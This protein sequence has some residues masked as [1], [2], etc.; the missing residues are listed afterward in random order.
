MEVAA[1]VE[2]VGARGLRAI[3]A[4]AG[5]QVR[6]ASDDRFQSGG[7]GLLIELDRTEH[8]AVIGHRDRLHPGGFRMFDQRADLVGSVEQ[9]ELRMDVKMDETHRSLPLPPGPPHARR[10]MFLW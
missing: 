2:V 9:A 4:A 10:A 8:V 1:A 7:S 6:L 5:S 3:A